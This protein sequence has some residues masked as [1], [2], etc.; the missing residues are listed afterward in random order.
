MRDENARGSKFGSARDGLA[1]FDHQ[2]LTF[3]EKATQ[4]LA[5]LAVT[6]SFQV[7]EVHAL[8][9]RDECALIS[10]ATAS[11]SLMPST[12]AERMPPA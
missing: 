1:E 8:A 11:A 12:P 6:Q 9:R 10:A 4:F 5:V 7:V 3:G 2:M